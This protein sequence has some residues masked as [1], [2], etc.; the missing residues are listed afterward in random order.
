M[1]RRDFLLSGAVGGIAALAAVK[2]GA[3]DTPSPR[4]PYPVIDTHT[5]FY[6]PA[7]PGGVAWPGKD[8][9]PLY[10]TMLPPDWQKVA[11][12]CGVTGT[13]VVEASPLVEDNQW[14]I[15]LATQ[16]T[17]VVGIVGRLPIGEP[18][19]AAFIDRFS[20][21]EKFRG[22]RI[23]SDSLQAGFENPDFM[24]DIERL[25]DKGLVV[26]V[27][28]ADVI[29]TADRLAELVPR[30]HVLLEHM[31][32]ARIAGE[33]PDPAWIDG[34]GKAAR[35]PNTFL[36][37]SHV[38]QSGRAEQEAPAPERYEP[39][40]AAAWQ[41]FGDHRVMFGSDWP[42]SGRHASYRAI[43]DA[44]QRFVHAR[45][46]EAEKWFFAESSRAAYGYGSRPAAAG[47]AGSK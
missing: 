26:D 19:C 43:F 12:P 44:A 28:G 42:V 17:C 7:R 39:W 38:L 1:Q 4:Y 21:H 8:D 36:K 31:A 33:A 29:A 25:A 24:R 34:I 13:I 35:H 2:A 47:A 5:H 3:A 11:N 37:V 46:E 15:D 45:G 14:L 6:D 32:G 18:G 16:H 22:V 23:K 20:K 27:I 30:M 10:R 41:A 9:A 40:L